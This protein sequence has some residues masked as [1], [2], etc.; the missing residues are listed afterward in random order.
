MKAAFNGLEVTDTSTAVLWAKKANRSR[1]DGH[2]LGG[3]SKAASGARAS[4]A[5]WTS[6]RKFF[7]GIRPSK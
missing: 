5:L 4:T 6:C 3:V 1:L 2:P 7:I